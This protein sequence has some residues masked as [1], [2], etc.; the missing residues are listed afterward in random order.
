MKLLGRELTH[1]PR[2]VWAGLE[3]DHEVVDGELVKTVDIIVIPTVVL[4]LR[5]G[6]TLR[7]LERLSRRHLGITFVPREEL[8]PDDLGA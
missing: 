8:P 1:D 3:W 2:K 7:N 4:K 5:L 6:L